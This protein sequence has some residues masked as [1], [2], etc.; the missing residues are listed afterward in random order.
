MDARRALLGG[1][2]V[3][4]LAIAGWWMFTGERRALG[5]A[6]AAAG[7]AVADAEADAESDPA[8]AP[9]LA[10]VPER[11]A[12]LPSGEPT[13]GEAPFA[14][15]D[16]SENA[17]HGSWLVVDP[18]GSPLAGVE[19][20]ITG[21]EV[22]LDGDPS[23]WI[24][25]S[26]EDG[27]V[28]GVRTERPVPREGW[29]LLARGRRADVE[30]ERT[31]VV[32]EPSA[33]SGVVTDTEGRPL[34]D[35]YV[36]V[37]QRVRL[38]GLSFPLL[39]AELPPR[40]Q[41]RSGADGAFRVEEV[42]AV[43]GLEL[44][45]RREGYRSRTLALPPGARA[46]LLVELEAEAEPDLTAVH[47]VV[48]AADGRPVP[49]ATVLFGFGW[50]S[51]RVDADDR[52]RFVVELAGLAAEAATSGGGLALFAR[53]PEL[54]LTDGRWSAA[55][56]VE[57]ATGSDE[58]PLELCFPPEPVAIAGRL[59]D[60]DGRPLEDWRIRLGTPTA[61][62]VG[63]QAFDDSHTVEG[64]VEA[65]TDAEG[66]F[67]LS[68]LLARSYSLVARA[69]DGARAHRLEDRTAP[70]EGLDWR[71]DGD[72]V[73]ARLAG[74]VV[75]PSGVP[76]AGVTV[77]LWTVVER[78]D[79]FGS[80]T[81]SSLGDARTTDAEGRFEFLDVPRAAQLALSDNGSPPLEPL[82]LDL[83]EVADPEDV[84]LVARRLRTVWIEYVGEPRDR[85]DAGR[86]QFELV[87]I[88]ADGEPRPVQR[89]GVRASVVNLSSGLWREAWLTADTAE[90]VFRARRFVGQRPDPDGGMRNA[91]EEEVFARFPIE[92]RSDADG[93]QRLRLVFPD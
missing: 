47:G 6:E 69:P 56:L 22:S 24:R 5:D 73:I 3:L 92:R 34:A 59:S 66:R 49:G 68:P 21:A 84:E 62:Q 26:D 10:P 46:G 15:P 9:A 38:G 54:G 63:V 93:P 11:A 29:V 20:W 28:R 91:Y 42:P 85:T 79:F 7:A 90:V 51:G 50:S 65:R 12:A 67:R 64:P 58:R 78:E 75:G 8:P 41:G 32:A 35:V 27:V 71:L 39:D 55:E 16:P 37:E 48:L 61:W 25:V 44:R 52:G 43:P 53:D 70:V 18:D 80:V 77:E 72:D 40:Q 88:T 74:R 57:G 89:D 2:V 45:F 17:E 82:E 60:A 31:L 14:G 86:E 30:P 33:V 36:G 13:A 76:E 1:V 81:S 23:P 83:A 4:A 87:A 19:V